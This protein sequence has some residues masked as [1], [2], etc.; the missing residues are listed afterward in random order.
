MN[1]PSTLMAFVSVTEAARAADLTPHAVRWRIHQGYVR[2]VERNVDGQYRIPAVE[3]V[4]LAARRRNSRA[5][6]PAV[7]A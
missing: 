7:E 2:G 6:A 5:N 4:K 1:K 3:A